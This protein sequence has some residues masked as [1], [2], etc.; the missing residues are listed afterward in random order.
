MGGIHM[1]F[2]KHF[3]FV[4]FLICSF[5]VFGITVNAVE[6]FFYSG[7]INIYFSESLNN[8]D[9]N[10]HVYI[11]LMVLRSDFE[12]YQINN[13]VNQ[14]YKDRYPN[15]QNFIHLENGDEI[16][17]FAYIEGAHLYRNKMEFR[18]VDDYGYYKNIS[19]I[20]MVIFDADGEVLA[21]SELFD[22]VNKTRFHI[23]R[24]QYS[25]SYD[26]LSF[27]NT[28]HHVFNGIWILIWILIFAISFFILLM[29]YLLEVIFG[30]RYKNFL[31]SVLFDSIVI[32]IGAYTMHILNETFIPATLTSLMIMSISLF[33]L[34]N[35]FN[36]FYLIQ[37]K[38]RIKYIITSVIHFIPV[39]LILKFAVVPWI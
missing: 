39:Y 8:E 19:K 34:M 20:R 24:G 28:R 11:E 7:D 36:F 14:E 16:S 30:I 10:H 32:W 15:H 33:V 3:S 6:E 1:K 25:A 27:S 13:T 21:S 17:Y 38:S 35:V 22:H 31:K 29:K 18:F 5:F 2:K 26:D 4:L 37:K 9:D 23:V 12:D